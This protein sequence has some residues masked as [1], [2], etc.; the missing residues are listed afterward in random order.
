MGG[1]ATSLELE[2]RVLDVEVTGQTPL[3]LVQ[4]RGQVS[5]LEAEVVH[6]DVRGQHGQAGGDLAGVPVMDRLNPCHPEQ[7]LAHL[8]QLQTPGRGLQQDIDALPQDSQG[9]GND[10]R[11]YEQR[12]HRVGTQPRRLR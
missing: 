5:V 10:Q 6:D 4:Q 11:P 3:E 2:R 1:M 8:A 12:N 9:S 7:V